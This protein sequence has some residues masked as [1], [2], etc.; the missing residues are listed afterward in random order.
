MAQK[1]FSPMRWTAATEDAAIQGA[2]EIVGVAREEIDYEVLDQ[3]AKGVTVR[4]K[5]R[6]ENAPVETV[7]EPFVDEAEPLPYEA[8]SVDEDVEA[9]LEIADDL[10]GESF[11]EEEL[12][13]SQPMLDAEAEELEAQIEPDSDYSRVDETSAAFVDSWRDD[14]DAQGVDEDQNGVDESVSRVDEE[15]LEE[16]APIDPAIAAR[17]QEIAEQ[18]LEKMGL[19]AAVV[20]SEDAPPGTLGLTI[21]GTDVGILIGKHGATLQAFQYLVNLTINNGVA[22][23]EG[24]RVVVDAGNYRAR[25]Q[26]SL[27]QTAR[28]AAQRVRMSGRPVRLDPMPSSERRIVH[29]FLQVEVG[30]ST[31]SE[32]REPQRR[33]VVFP[34]ETRQDG[35]LRADP[36]NDRPFDR[37]SG[38]RGMGG[39]NRGRG[40][41][42]SRR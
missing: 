36:V 20:P 9:E 22:V 38:G 30:V 35:T 1:K 39:Y 19:D 18:F 12:P 42:G 17:A 29:A 37:A 32:G 16:A 14:D 11:A 25:R 13:V 6:E 4:I 33:I 8:V 2:L 27:E 31:Q 28:M 7:P 23:D 3:S 34:A 24:V 21:E 26:N 41:R 10:A 40:G 5:P 15:E